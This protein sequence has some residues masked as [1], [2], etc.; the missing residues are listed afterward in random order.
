[1]EV[2]RSL[3]LTPV[4]INVYY[5]AHPLKYNYKHYLH[6]DFWVI[7][8]QHHFVHVMIFR[9]Y[10]G[11]QTTTGSLLSR[12]AHHLQ[13]GF[14]LSSPHEAALTRHILD[15]LGQALAHYEHEVCMQYSCITIKI[16]IL[17]YI[18]LSLASFNLLVKQ[19]RKTINKISII[20]RFW[21]G[22]WRKCRLCTL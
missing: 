5:S 9:H 14:T 17:F 1:M 7:E 20:I 10:M 21:E 4:L 8:W 19:I 18:I 22:V 3:P 11:K 15:H 2:P 13:D 16:I 6:W 12:L